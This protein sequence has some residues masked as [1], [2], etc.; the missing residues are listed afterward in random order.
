MTYSVTYFSE[1]HLYR[2]FT[3]MPL[4]RRLPSHYQDGVYQP[5]GWMRPN[6]RTV[7]EELMSGLTGNTSYR[8]KTA[9]LV[10][11]GMQRTSTFMI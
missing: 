8:L 7:S 3:D 5:S 2:T 9:F 1:Y 6:P 4:T 11:F 10:F